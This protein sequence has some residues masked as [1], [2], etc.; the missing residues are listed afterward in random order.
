MV[1]QMQGVHRYFAV[2]NAGNVPGAMVAIYFA[3]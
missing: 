1:E 3:N 2:G